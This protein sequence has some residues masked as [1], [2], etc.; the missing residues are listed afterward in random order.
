[1]P[2]LSQQYKSPADI[3]ST[4]PIFP[5]AGA[6]LLPRGQLPLVIFEPRY[7]EMINSSMSADRLVGMIQP[8]SEA[9]IAM[10]N[11]A[12]LRPKIAHVGCVGRITSFTET[13]D[14]RILITLSGIARFKVV[15][16]LDCPYSYR[17]C[18]IDCEP[19]AV[20]F[21][22]GI[23]EDGVNREVLLSTF[24]KYL[25]AHDL[26]ADWDSVHKSSN[27]TLVNSLCIMSPYGPQEKQAL[28]EAGD[29]KTRADI[30]IAL[31]E[32]ELA[33]TT[34]NTDKTLQ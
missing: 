25:S 15:K 7:L 8:A 32:M 11:D 9:D 6:L 24:K 30:L 27:E 23:G 17:M 19:Y 31:T 2:Y 22:P 12:D 29:L 3:P 33:Q 21:T 10:Q 34:E 14:G 13:G 20:D 26:E 16:E 1:M 4:V 28:L 5:L 18:Q